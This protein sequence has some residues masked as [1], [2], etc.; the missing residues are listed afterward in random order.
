MNIFQFDIYTYILVNK[1]VFMA[2]EIFKYVTTSHV[3]NVIQL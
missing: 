3:N 1:Y 2:E